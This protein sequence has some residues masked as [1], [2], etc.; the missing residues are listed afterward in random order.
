MSAVYCATPE[1]RAGPSSI[2]VRL[3]M[4]ANS[5]MGGLPQSI[6]RILDRAANL[7]VAGA[8]AD[9]AGNRGANVGFRRIAVPLQQRV[10]GHHHAGRAES[11]LRSAFLNESALQSIEFPLRRETLDGGDLRLLITRRQH[12]AREHG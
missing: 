2:G 8:A 5:D 10:Q 6:H 7:H 1:T 3:P 11:A 12:H 9:V 4:T